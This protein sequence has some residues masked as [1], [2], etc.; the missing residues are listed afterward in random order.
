M[1]DAV[2]TWVRKHLIES[3]LRVAM[4][5]RCDRTHGLGDQGHHE[6]WTAVNTKVCPW[7]TCLLTRHPTFTTRFS[8]RLCTYLPTVTKL[9]SPRSCIHAKKKTEMRFDV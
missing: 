2:R 5:W 9:Q 1:L 7:P 4:P 8:I 3:S 6:T